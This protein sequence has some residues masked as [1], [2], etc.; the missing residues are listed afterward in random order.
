MDYVRTEIDQ[1]VATVTFDR[2]PVNALDAQ[3]F[4][5]IATKSPICLRLA[6]ESLN[7]VED[8]PLKD[9]YRLEKRPPEWTWT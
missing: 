7:R 4:R 8:L 6:K 3:A 5:E 2:P 9:G 1:R